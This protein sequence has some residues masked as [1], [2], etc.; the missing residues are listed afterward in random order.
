[1]ANKNIV[2]EHD[3]VEIEYLEGE[4]RWRFELRGRERKVE[5]LANAR[6]AIDKPEPKERAK[7]EKIGC[8]G[9]GQYGGDLWR[10]VVTSVAESDRYTRRPQVWVLRDGQSRKESAGNVYA[11]SPENWKIL[12]ECKSIDGQRE[13][14]RK[15]HESLVAKLV[16]VA[17]PKD[18]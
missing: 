16:P 17:L 14:L 9:R 8:I 6:A 7:F 4:N 13:T 2:V 5:S 11:D 3:G 18:D 15:M 12:E 1:M 10:G